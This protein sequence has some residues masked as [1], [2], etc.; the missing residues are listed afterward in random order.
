MAQANG[1]YGS[2][3]SSATFK[4]DEYFSG[5][6]IVSVGPAGVPGDYNGN[7]V[8]DAADYVLWRKGG[9]LA[10]EVDTPGTVNA[11]DFAAWRTRFGN[12]AGSGSELGSDAAVP[13]PGAISMMLFA[14]G[15]LLVG[16][17]GY[18]RRRKG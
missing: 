18:R 13:E 5:T 4:F 7:G 3:A 17:V 10:N 6:G 9:P 15:S 11:A 12:T 1:S 14:I 16:G 2:T 8:V